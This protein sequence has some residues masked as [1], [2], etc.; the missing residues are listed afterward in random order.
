MH[1]HDHEH[2][3]YS[4]LLYS[5]VHYHV[6]VYYSRRPHSGEPCGTVLSVAGWYSTILASIGGTYYNN[7]GRNYSYWRSMFSSDNNSTSTQETWR[8]FSRLTQKF[9]TEESNSEKSVN[10]IKNAYITI[11][12]DYTLLKSALAIFNLYNIKFGVLS[13]GVLKINAFLG[14]DKHQH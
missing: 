12:A 7:E 11:Q 9:G 1:E 14:I 3:L 13:F 4:H 5:S 8:V 6:L 2:L 10:L